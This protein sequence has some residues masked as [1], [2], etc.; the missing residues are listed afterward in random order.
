MASRLMRLRAAMRERDIPALLVS[1]HENILYLSG[2]TGSAGM[3]VVTTERACLCTD[4]RYWQQAAQESPEWE[5]V[6]VETA[7]L[8]TMRE[9]LDSLPERTIGFEA[10]HLSVAQHRQLT[11]ADTPVTFTLVPA[12]ALVE[13]LR[14]VKEA[15]ELARIRRAVQLT[16]ATYAHLLSIIAVGVS[17]YELAL[18]A[19]W[20]MRRHGAD[21]VAFDIIVAA[22]PR[23]ALPHAAPGARTLAPG[24][25]LVID[26][27]ARVE[28]Y[29]ADLT[30][31]LAVAEATPLA[32]E[33]YRIC[34]TAQCAGET[35]I[36]A[37]MTGREADA[38]VRAVIADA[39][40][41][42]NFGHG[43]G[44]GVG[45]E[46]HEAPRLSRMSDDVLPVG[47]AVT[48]EPGIYL[49][50]GGVRIEDLVVV[51]EDG[52]DVLTAAPKPE[53]L[54]VYG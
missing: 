22:G 37:G 53:F 33:I 16:D 2:F 18:E 47:A 9:L 13:S 11:A 24:D 45:L 1:Q 26:M 10:D 7:L 35:G 36:H 30:R 23:S 54:P 19:E 14:L 15:D 20:Y 48:I 39:G 41:G 52:V 51:T 40:Y 50:I 17:E 25:L 4:F 38:L 5:L 6:R 32:Q 29:C 12:P 8:P 43:T 31:T 28:R 34:W 3:L 46:V 27:G 42:D 44:H 21:A 49:P